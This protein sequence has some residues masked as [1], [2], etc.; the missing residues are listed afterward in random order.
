[1]IFPRLITTDV[2]EG[3]T[4]LI[5]KACNQCNMATAETTTTTLKM[6]NSPAR[7]RISSRDD[8]WKDIRA[9]AKPSP[10]KGADGDESEDKVTMIGGQYKDNVTEQRMLDGRL[11]DLS[12]ERYKYM[13]QVAWQR[14]AFIDKQKRK[15][16]MMKDLL[17]GVDTTMVQAGKRNQSERLQEKINNYKQLVD[18]SYG[19]DRK[20]RSKQRESQL[21]NELEGDSLLEKKLIFPIPVVT[22]SFS[23]SFSTSAQRRKI[24]HTEPPSTTRRHEHTRSEPMDRRKKDVMFPSI[25]DQQGTTNGR[26]SVPLTF[27]RKDHPSSAA[28]PSRHTMSA[29]SMPK[30]LKYRASYDRRFSCLERLL[31]TPYDGSNQKTKV[32]GVD[33][34]SSLLNQLPPTTP[35][36]PTPVITTTPVPP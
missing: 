21:D 20:N 25:V 8:I 27:M 31:T 2:K 4:S 10:V 28:R 30:Y 12:K 26:Q 29:G 36:P 22:A 1:M 18:S 16:S 13:V 24:F 19:K 14:K 6:Q 33:D 15:T 3:S 9:W 5:W 35:V 34:M 32:I 17:T 11:L 23:S 7:M